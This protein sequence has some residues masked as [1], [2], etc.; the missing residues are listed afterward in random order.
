MVVVPR[1]GGVNRAHAMRRATLA[2]R[3]SRHERQLPFVGRESIVVKKYLLSVSALVLASPALAQG[4]DDVV[5]ADTIRADAIT[6]I[7]TGSETLLSRLGQPVSVITA[8]EIASVQGPDIT[9]VLE[10]IPGLTFT[11]NGGIGSFTGVRLRGADAEQ[12]LVLVDGV[13]V[14]DVSAP[15]GGFDFGTLTP[16]GVERI[17]VLRGSNSVVWGSAALG[18]VIAI[19]SREFNGVEASAEYGANDTATADAA[20]GLATDRAAITLNGGYTRTDGVSAAAAGTEPDG[21]RQWRVGGKGRLNLTDSLSVVA[22]ARYADSRT[23]I[24]G[25]GPPTYFIFGDTPEYQTTRQASGR[26]GLR[27]VSDA[28]T[29]NTGFALS[30]TKRDYYDPTFGTAPSYGYQGR[31]ERVDLTGRLTLPANFSLDFGGDSE[32]TRFSSTFDAEAKANL[33]SGHALLGWST[34]R[35]SLAAGV[36]VDDHSRFG[37]A[38]T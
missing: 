37:T 20:A 10:R 33:T 36:R 16:G 35:A 14:E 5:I 22:N 8:D 21:F 26:A 31:S 3:S 17:D 1:P 4:V 13:R 2:P 25:Y 9:R 11:R 34:D 30:D 6:V 18:G 7:A 27:Y 38:W 24:D 19:Q 28:L 12:V 29:L 23:D 32:W 15:S